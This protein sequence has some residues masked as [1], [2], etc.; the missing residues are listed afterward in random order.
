MLFLIAVVGSVDSVD[1]SAVSASD[2]MTA[3]GLEEA[4]NWRKSE[5]RGEGR[6]RGR[7]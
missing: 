4:K 3:T 2:F 5:S 6:S 1:D 7:K